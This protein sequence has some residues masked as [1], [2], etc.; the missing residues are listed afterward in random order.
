MDDEIALERH[1][2]D[3]FG[4]VG[5]ERAEGHRQMMVVGKLFALETQFRHPRP[6]VVIPVYRSTLISASR[7]LLIVREA[8][9][10]NLMP[11]PIRHIFPLKVLSGDVS[12]DIRSLVD[13]FFWKNCIIARKAW[14][15][16]RLMM[17]IE[18]VDRGSPASRRFSYTRLF[19]KI[20][21]GPEDYHG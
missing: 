8:A 19:L 13:R 5:H 21:R 11:H 18:Q 16:A 3:A 1:G 10:V 7:L 20:L 9:D 6:F 2:A 4:F 15:A 12:L 17:V 14:G